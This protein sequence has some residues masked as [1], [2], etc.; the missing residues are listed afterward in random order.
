MMQQPI[1][2][3]ELDLFIGFLASQEIKSNLI[4]IQ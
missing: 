3:Q 4:N 2:Q 1:Q